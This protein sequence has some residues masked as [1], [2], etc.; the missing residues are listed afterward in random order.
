MMWLKRVVYVLLGLFALLLVGAY[1]LPR[2][3]QVERRILLNAS[4]EQVFAVVNSFA[5]FNKW[6]PWFALDP[7]AQYRYSG[8]AAGVGARMEWVGNAAVGSGAQEILASEPHSRVQLRLEFGD[9]GTPLA[10]YRVQA[11]A[12][13]TEL[14]WRFEQDLGYNPMFRWFG[15]MMDGFIGADYERGLSQLK[16]LLEQPATPAS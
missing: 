9:M 6:S 14:I 8:P 12:T 15:L 16:V 7:Q 5:E 2:H 11:T 1:L 10:E 4:P 13:G 3:V